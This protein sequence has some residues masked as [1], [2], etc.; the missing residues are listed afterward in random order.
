MKC[1]NGAQVHTQLC[2]V[3][4]NVKSAHTS[5]CFFCSSS[6]RDIDDS[7]IPLK[8]T[9]ILRPPLESCWLLRKIDTVNLLVKGYT[10][11]V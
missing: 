6:F 7:H 5:H 2:T 4:E 10:L 8:T 1:S 3:L 9:G 11:E